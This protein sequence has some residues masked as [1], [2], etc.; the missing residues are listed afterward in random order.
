MYIL[1][2]LFHT[3][4]FFPRC[5]CSHTCGLS[6]PTSVCIV[7]CF[8]WRHCHC[9]HCLRMAVAPLDISLML[10]QPHPCAS[11]HTRV[12]GDIFILMTC[13]PEY[14]HAT[15]HT[16]VF[17]CVFLFTP[18]HMLISAFVIVAGSM[19]I[20]CSIMSF[21]L[22]DP[23]RLTFANHNIII[24]VDTVIRLCCLILYMLGYWARHYL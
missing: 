18:L 23:H 12:C 19:V 7:S 3:G 9:C 8:Y 4:G 1:L 24:I 21:L 10:L 16:R 2:L 5:D 14:S 22:C 11:Q 13:H 6:T 15:F 20:F 17:T